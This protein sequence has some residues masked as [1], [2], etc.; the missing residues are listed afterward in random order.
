[1]PRDPRRRLAVLLLFLVLVSLTPTLLWLLPL[2]CLLLSLRAAREMLLRALLILP[3]SAMLAATAWWSGNG[4]MAL[5]LLV[6]SY[7]SVVAVL[8]FN[9]TTPATVWIGVLRSWGVPRALVEVLQFV[10]RYLS[11]V[12]DEARRMRVAATARGGFRYD[13]AAGA[14]GVLFVRSWERGE[15]VHRAML[16]RGYDG[17]SL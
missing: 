16:A 12:T 14:I 5:T 13:A 15:R 10:H 2:A 6:K 8:A 1:M 3:F 9:A 4:W 17:R 11:V 7:V